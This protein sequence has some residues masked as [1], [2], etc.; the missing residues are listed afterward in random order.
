MIKL[1]ITCLLVLTS[2]AIGYGQYNVEDKCGHYPGMLKA[3]QEYK[4]DYWGYNFDSLLNDISIWEQSTFVEVSSI[5][6]SVQD[7][8]LYELII[9]D[10]SFPAGNKHRIYIH[11][12][13]HPNEV[14]SFW[15][16]DEIINLLLSNTRLAGYLREQCIFHI[17]P[18]FNPDGVELELPRENANSI[19]IESNWDAD[20]SEVEVVHLQDR[21]SALML[22][23]NPIKI[24]LNMHSAYACKRYFVYHHENGTSTAFA[25]E[26]RTFITNIRDHFYEGIEPWSYYVSWQNGTPTRYPESWWWINYDEQVMAL[27]YEDMNCSSAGFYDK[28]AYSMLHGISD[29]LELGY[30]NSI[31]D[32][33]ADRLQVKAYPNPFTEHVVVEWNDFRKVDQAIILDVTGKRVYTFPGSINSE[34]SLYW[35]G[36]NN[37]GQEVCEGAYILQLVF[38]N[39]TESV[40]LIKQL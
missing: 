22:E 26:E 4:G 9:T 2:I 3:M 11:A 29:Y 27:T 32:F 31:D 39:S 40:M 20:T 21:F 36:R 10:K 23:Q 34:G 15:V 35:D 6:K 13:T 18:M 14:Q 25:N 16:T 28:T 37:D 5:G 33:T 7:R 38:G 19:D 8:N 30:V 17:I 24:A 1:R 12:R